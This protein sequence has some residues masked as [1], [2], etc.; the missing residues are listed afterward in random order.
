MNLYSKKLIGKIMAVIGLIDGI[1][2][3]DLKKK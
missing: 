3:D 2:I 1:L